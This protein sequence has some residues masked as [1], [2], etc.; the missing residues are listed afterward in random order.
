MDIV[1][2][3]YILITISILSPLYPII[4]GR[5]NRNVILWWYAIADFT[6][7]ISV[8]LLRMVFHSPY[9]GLSGNI[10]HYLEFLFVVLAYQKFLNIK[11]I[12]VIPILLAGLTFFII[13]LNQTSWILADTQ[14]SAVFLFVYLLLSLFGFYSILKEKKIIFIERSTFFWVNV[15]FLIYSSGDIILL[16]FTDYLRNYNDKLYIILFSTFYLLIN[17]L[18]NTLLGVAL[19][20]RKDE[21]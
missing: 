2:I 12:I 15:A 3:R 16:I 6:A 14:V 19:S 4:A 8:F 1:Q 7:D 18:K 9:F 11:N 21:T 17:I 20:R 13:K 10:Y 5:K